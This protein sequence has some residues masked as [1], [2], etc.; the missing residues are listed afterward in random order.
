M[1]T[2]HA[3]SNYSLLK[4]TIPIEEL[5]SF[6]V[7]EGSKSVVLTD[8]NGMYGIL[9]F[10]KLAL[11]QNIKPILGSLIDDPNNSNEAA[12]FLAKN[13]NGYS[14]LCRL[15]TTRKLKDD[16]K[17]YQYIN[18]T[19]NDLFVITNSIELLRKLNFNKSLRE[20]LF[21]ELIITNKL[22]RKTRELYNFAKENELLITASHPAYFLNKEDYLLHKTVTAIRLNKTLN[23]LTEDDLVDEEFY[24]KNP[25]ELDEIWRK[26][27]E[28]LKNAERITE[29]CNVELDFGTHKYPHFDLPENETS[30][31][32]LWKIAF[33][34]LEKR[35]QPITDEAVKRLQEELEI[36][37]EMGFTDYFLI[38]WDIIREAK[39]RGMMHIGRGS[40]ANSLVSYVLGFTEVD[41]IKHNFYFAR[42]LNKGRL[43]PPDI[44]LDFSWKER[45]EII[46][47]I[48]D[49][50]S[51]DKVAMIS[52][53]VT[54][55]ARS[56]FRET[57]KV[58]GISESEI[59]EYSKFIPWTSAKNLGNL[60][61]KFPESRKLNFENEPWKSIIKIASQLAGFPRH[62]SIHPSGIVIS[63][64][65]ITNYVA[66]E[67]AKNKGLG[68][69]VTQPDMYPI[70]DFGL[71]KIDILSQ[72]SI[73]VFKDTMNIL[74]KDYI[75]KD[76]KIIDIKDYL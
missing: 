4:G 65:S 44:D 25:D 71:I 70:E 42:F 57:A 8:D 9:Q 1:I 48:F 19:P 16:F 69:I 68:L 27:P 14:Q 3:H 10:A 38:V 37:N 43:S 15:I 12:L 28:A 24:L 60:A 46:K 26:I 7:K 40:A 11:Q 75:S 61:A 67:F 20:N 45:D 50:Y 5:I 47:Y 73:G 31:S 6:A 22:K 62:L 59:S 53:T 66:L 23:S 21:V 63:D 41:P 32:F 56:A 51:Y 52:T 54:F 34:G 76:A 30:Y 18:E 49:K 64:K 33:H 74:N 36:I 39:N 72:R 13:N 29:E 58:F 2:L 17:L 55:R 35:Y